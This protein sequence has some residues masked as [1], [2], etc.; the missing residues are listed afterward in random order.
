MKYTYKYMWWCENCETEIEVW[1]QVAK[2]HRSKN[3]ICYLWFLLNSCEHRNKD[4]D[5]EKWVRSTAFIF[6][7]VSTLLSHL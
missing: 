2:K 6:P 7:L 3:T 4:E 1:L 5:G